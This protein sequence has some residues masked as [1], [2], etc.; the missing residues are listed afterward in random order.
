MNLQYYEDVLEDSR[1]VCDEFIPEP[2]TSDPKINMAYACLKLVGKL[3]KN[4]RNY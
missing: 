1:I 4:M 3:R 2:R